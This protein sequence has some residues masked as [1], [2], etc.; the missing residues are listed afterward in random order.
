MQLLGMHFIALLYCFCLL[1]HCYIVAG[2]FCL[3]LVHFYVIAV[4]SWMWGYINIFFLFTPLLIINFLFHFI[5]LINQ[6][7]RSSNN[8]ACL[9]KHLKI[10]MHMKLVKL[11]WWISHL[12]YRPIDQLSN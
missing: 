2:V 10:L 3:F 6:T 11:R 4:V 9:S 8:V 1:E 5:L 7:I 12:F